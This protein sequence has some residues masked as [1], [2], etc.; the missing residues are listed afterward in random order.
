MVFD[1]KESNRLYRLNH[2]DKRKE[3]NKE[4]KKT[5]KGKKIHIIGRWKNRGLISDNYDELYYRYINSTACELC[6]KEYKNT[7]DRCL[8][9]CHNTGLFRYIL[10]RSCNNSSKLCE[11]PINNTS[12]HKNI[13]ETKNNTYRVI[14]TINKILYQKTF[15]TI[16]EAIF[17]RDFLL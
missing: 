6:N 1:K 11:T 14:I 7:Y 16:E 8:D 12:G 17:Y 15:K 2:K 10:C 3:F 13:R 9:H 5:D 4:Y